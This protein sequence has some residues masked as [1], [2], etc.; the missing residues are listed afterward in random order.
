MSYILEDMLSGLIASRQMF[1]KHLEGL[2]ED[3]WDWKPYAE[4]FSIRQTLRH[5]ILDDRAAVN[6]LETGKEPDYEALRAYDHDIAVL[7]VLLDE[8]HQ[9]LLS[10]LRRHYTD[11]PHDTE[12]CVW[13]SWY[14]L[15]SGIAYFSSEDFYHMGQV[16]FIRMASDPTWDYYGA[17]YNKF[18][19]TGNP[20][21]YP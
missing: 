19:G 15:P 3:Q 16:A 8:S 17:I 6:S 10:C 13:G 21:P 7:R 20:N 5:L 18:Y 1:F 14:K 2:R 11:A 12:I 9:N 4:C